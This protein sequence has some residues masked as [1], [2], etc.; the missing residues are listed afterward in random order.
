ML[1][2][3]C[4]ILCLLFAG[5]APRPVAGTRVT[6]ASIVTLVRPQLVFDEDG[7]EPIAQ[8]YAP[9]CEAFAVRDGGAVALLSAAHCAKTDADLHYLSPNGFG[10]GHASVIRREAAKDLVWLKPADG[11][12]LVPLE[13][14]PPPAVWAPV[15]ALSNHFAA[16]AAGRVTAVYRGGFYETDLQFWPGW[17]GAPVLD[18]AGRVWGVVVGCRAV[19]RSAI[20][21]DIR[22]LKIGRVAALRP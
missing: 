22:C 19:P 4:L 9:F 6:G 13:T 16:R 14:A 3:L 17:S 11:A 15:F 5:C 21:Q 12:G 10:H 7:V 20:E 1:K 8:R 18:N 2:F